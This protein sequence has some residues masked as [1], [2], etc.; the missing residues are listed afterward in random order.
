MKTLIALLLCWPMLA[1]SQVLS[2]Y[3]VEP[4]LDY[5]RNYVTMPS[6][7]KNGTLANWVTTSS[8]SIARDT[9]AADSLD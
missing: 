8:A 1:F 7:Y 9:D 2:P 5:R 6:P 4:M 3:N